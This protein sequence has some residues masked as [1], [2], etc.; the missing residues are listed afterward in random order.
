MRRYKETSTK[1]DKSGKTVYTTT[2]YPT[3]PIEDNDQFILSKDGDRLDSLA[4]RYFG[5]TNLWWIIS[6][7]NGIK[8]GIGIEAGTLF[9]IPSNGSKIIS[10]YKRI[11]TT[12]VSSGGTSS[13]GGS[14]GGGSA[15]G[16]GGY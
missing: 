8:G 4:F 14:G 3:I 16:G 2:Y 10:D 9:R 12:N 13:G 5:D 15:G 7:A 1:K 6:K 11:N